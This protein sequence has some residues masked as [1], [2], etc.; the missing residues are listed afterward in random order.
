MNTWAQIVNGFVESSCACVF[1]WKLVQAMVEH[2]IFQQRSQ[3]NVT[4]VVIMF[5]EP[6]E[7]Q[8]AA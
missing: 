2:A 1:V 4:A 3:D 7:F 8:N 5:K 6:R